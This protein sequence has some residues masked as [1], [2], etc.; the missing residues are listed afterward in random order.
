MKESLTKEL[1]E[2]AFRQLRE[3]NI[4]FSKKYPGDSPERQP[5]HTVYGGAHL[6]KSDSAIKLG[7]FA[8][9]ALHQFAPEPKVFAEVLG[10]SD[11]LGRAVYE[12]VLDKLNREPVEDF[13]IDFEDG[14]GNRSDEEEDHHAI[15]A[16]D[17]V[18]RGLNDG[19]LPPFIGIR[20]KPFTAELHDRAVRTLDLFVSTLVRETHGRLPGTFVVTL[21]KTVP[22]LIG[23]VDDVTFFIRG[24]ANRDATVNIADPIFTLSY[25]FLGGEAPECPDAADA[26][27][28]GKL[29]LSDAVSTLTY[30][31]EGSSALP[32][33]SSVP[34][35]DPSPDDLSRCRR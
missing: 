24:D 35:G 9:K 31:F 17:E 34:G 18:R 11:R 16:A 30:L 28:N 4:A 15:A 3:A 7:A 19:H 29:E 13:R 8:L 26:D 5:V 27:D 6:F 25:L 21:P 22:G 20:I 14:Y 1:T 10:L 23:I 32:P 12:R 33:P 2:K